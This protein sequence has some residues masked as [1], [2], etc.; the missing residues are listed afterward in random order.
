MS[1]ETNAHQVLNMPTQ[2][3]FIIENNWWKA[4]CPAAVA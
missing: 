4:E 1:T 2:V 3:L